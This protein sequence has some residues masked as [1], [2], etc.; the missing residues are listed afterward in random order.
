MQH[1]QDDE[2]Q[3][4]ENR[5]VDRIEQ[6]TRPPISS[7]EN[8]PS[9]TMV[10]TIAKSSDA[11]SDGILPWVNPV[12]AN[13]SSDILLPVP[14]ASVGKEIATESLPTE[15]TFDMKLFDKEDDPFENLELQTLD[16]FE[17]LRTVLQGPEPLGNH[18]DTGP[19]QS[20]SV[21]NNHTRTVVN[22]W[23]NMDSS[24][25]VTSPVV[26]GLDSEPLYENVNRSTSPVNIFTMTQTNNQ[27]YV[28]VELRKKSNLFSESDE[29]SQPSVLTNEPVSSLANMGG[30]VEMP[31][32]KKS[33]L[34]PIKSVA[35]NTNQLRHSSAL[36]NGELKN[37]LYENV[38]ISKSG[39]LFTKGLNDSNMYSRH[40]NVPKYE[41][42]ACVDKDNVNGTGEGILRNTKSNP[43]IYTGENREESPVQHPTSYTPPPG[44]PLSGHPT[45]ITPPP[46]KLSG[47]VNINPSCQ[48]YYKYIM[49]LMLIFITRLKVA[50]DIVVAM[51]VRNQFG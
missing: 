30:L 39:V 7:E 24:Q 17:E 4:E 8:L 19:S 46:V 47:Q 22:N 18:P 38:E 41:N 12:I 29:S 32:V 10:E 50:K 5:V 48:R 11:V 51:S 2:A 35:S 33:V 13:L 25:S 20:E 23:A 40:S 37:N 44:R 16:D 34:P 21:E 9:Y 36:L 27:N 43:D 3:A 45:S 28:N 26:N 31:L 42:M 1:A 49:L 14:I 6:F 15:S